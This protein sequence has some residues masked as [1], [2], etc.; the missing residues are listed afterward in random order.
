MSIHVGLLPNA[1]EILRWLAAEVV[2]RLAEFRPGTG[3]AGTAYVTVLW[4]EPCMTLLMPLVEEQI[5]QFSQQTLPPRATANLVTLL[6]GHRMPS[7]AVMHLRSLATCQLKSFQAPELL[8]LASGLA[9]S[10]TLGEPLLDGDLLQDIRRALDVAAASAASADGCSKQWTQSTKNAQNLVKHLE[11]AQTLANFFETLVISKPAGWSCAGAGAKDHGVPR[12]S[13][14][15]EAFEEIP[16]FQDPR[17]D[18]G[19]AHRL[20]VETS[21]AMLLGMTVRSYWRLRLEFAAK[22]VRRQYWAVVHGTLSPL[23]IPQ[24]LDLPLKILRVPRPTTQSRHSVQTKSTVCFD[25]GRRGT[26][27]YTDLFCRKAMNFTAFALGYSRNISTQTISSQQ[28]LV[29]TVSSQVC[30]FVADLRSLA[31]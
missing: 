29:R 10:K 1:G 21:G 26:N 25:A 30:H 19:L 5:L 6:Y 4:K 14:F 3:V 11:F 31:G 20:D 27:V 24:Q 13:E 28:T 18:N 2:W 16:V 7:P 12:L 23:H 17:A 15:L 9:S 8:D 22:E